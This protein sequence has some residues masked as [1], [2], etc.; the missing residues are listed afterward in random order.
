MAKKKIVYTIEREF[1]GKYDVKEL[2]GRIIA[3]RIKSEGEVKIPN[4]TIVCS[5]I[6]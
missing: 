5:L 2:A 6:K 1:L 4:R 3:Q